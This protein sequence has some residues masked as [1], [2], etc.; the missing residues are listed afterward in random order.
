MEN[1]SLFRKAPEGYNCEDVERYINSLKAEY[2]KVY[3]YAKASEQN[4]EKLKKICI[5]LSNENKALKSVSV[6]EEASTEAAQSAE[7]IA[8][9]SAE[10]SSQA[11]SLKEKLVK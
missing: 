1:K 10:L 6:S 11:A 7:K 2:K 4:N 9:L 5:A 8:E 3:E